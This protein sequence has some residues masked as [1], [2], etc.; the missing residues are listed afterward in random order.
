MEYIG[1]AEHP[2]KRSM[3]AHQ[4][5]AKRSFTNKGIPGPARKFAGHILEGAVW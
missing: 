5:G 4:A 1:G 3:A 2:A